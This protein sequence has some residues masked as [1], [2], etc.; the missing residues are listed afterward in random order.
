MLSVRPEGATGLFS[1]F[2][3]YFAFI[4]PCILARQRAFLFKH[5]FPNLSVNYCSYNLVLG[6]C[7]R[8]GVVLD[9]PSPGPVLDLRV[10]ASGP[11]VWGLFSVPASIPIA[12]KSLFAFEAPRASYSILSPALTQIFLVSIRVSPWRR[13]CNNC[14]LPL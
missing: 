6:V 11:W 14:E 5:S 10:Y 2:L 13:E 12:T 4:S 1:A 7:C 9:S 3:F 8:V